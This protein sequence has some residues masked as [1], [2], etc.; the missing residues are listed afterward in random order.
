MVFEL[1][2]RVKQNYSCGVGSPSSGSQKLPPYFTYRVLPCFCPPPLTHPPP[3]PPDATMTTQQMTHMLTAG[4]LNGSSPAQYY[5]YIYT[6]YLAFRGPWLPGRF[7]LTPK[8]EL[9]LNKY[10]GNV[11]FRY[12]REGSI[13]L[14][15]KNKHIFCAYDQRLIVHDE[16]S[17]LDSGTY[18]IPRSAVPNHVQHPLQRTRK[19][20]PRCLR[21]PHSTIPGALPM[22]HQGYCTANQCT[23]DLRPAVLSPNTGQCVLIQM[24]IPWSW[25]STLPAPH[26]YGT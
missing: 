13:R 17:H 26:G 18:G 22:R 1:G 10:A 15:E 6:Y 14:C 23:M 21:S 24:F 16:L 2:H 11:R 25:Q 20:S 9:P 8:Q 12:L 19:R 3:K 7:P 4:T 5:I